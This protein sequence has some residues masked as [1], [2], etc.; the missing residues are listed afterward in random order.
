MKKI[1]ID[2]FAEASEAILRT[3]DGSGEWNAALEAVARLM[4]GSIGGLMFGSNR[5]P[6][7]DPLAVDF[8]ELYN[9]PPG[10][11]E[12]YVA[13]TAP[14]GGDPAS[15]EL[16]SQGRN[17]PLIDDLDY[18]DR[19]FPE[20]W[21]DYRDAVYRPHHVGSQVFTVSSAQNEPR[22]IFGMASERW[23]KRQSEDNQA[24]LRRL[25]PLIRQSLTLR[26]KLV[27]AEGKL[28]AIKGSIDSLTTGLLWLD[29]YGR[30]VDANAAA[31]RILSEGD[32]LRLIAN[33]P[34][35]M[36]GSAKTELERAIKGI[37]AGAPMRQV[38]VAR[39]SGRQPYFL[40]LMPPCQEHRFVSTIKVTCYITDP[41]AVTTGVGSAARAL[42]GLTAAES[43]VV[44][45]LAAGCE[46][47]SIATMR[48][49]SLSTVRAQIKSSLAK[50]GVNRQIDLVRMALS[51]ASGTQF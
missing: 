38:A 28:E 30:M 49:I 12:S 51:A 23:T 8:H 36:A 48:R 22:F 9:P 40:T 35:A 33:I 44:Q 14:T 37:V 50:A 39:P 18:M 24:I 20:Y 42:F 19:Q 15:F 11:I 6:D 29:L 10:F 47:A 31:Q 5:R 13:Y 26:S 46:P 25:T 7:L 34:Q 21:P 27:Y 16:M 43:E 41:E 17:A 2:R 1:D 32:G 45:L 3:A 4:P